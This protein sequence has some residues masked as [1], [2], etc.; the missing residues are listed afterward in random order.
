[1]SKVDAEKIDLTELTTRNLNA[2]I[3]SA[4]EKSVDI[5]ILNPQARH[6]L[7]VGI[8]KPCRITFEGSVGYYCCSFSSGP[9][10][11]IK[12]NAGWGLGSNLMKGSIVLKRN[13]G[14]SIACSMRGG[15]VFVSGNVGARAGISMK[16]GRL[17]IGG[18]SG[19]LTGYLMQKGE[20]IVCGDV[21]D[22]VADSMYEGVI[23]VGGKIDS[24][25][26]DAKLDK[27]SESE[28]QLI[29]TRLSKNGIKNKF[30]WKKI[31]SKKQLY[32]YDALEPM[33]KISVGR[34][35]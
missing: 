9:E 13:S 6:N 16:G 18:N 3:K 30:E 11:I 20:M 23:Y 26:N 1:M 14:S 8:L 24:L 21:G 31:V 2:K 28:I 34:S 10:F 33:E 5:T 35:I 4:A 22:D 19:Y 25:G 12:G 17:I 29:T 32:H 27:I 15:E 7:A